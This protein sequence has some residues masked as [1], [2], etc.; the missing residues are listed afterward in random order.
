MLLCLSGNR[1]YP[2]LHILYIN[3]YY[4]SI[5]YHF[6]YLNLTVFLS[7]KAIPPSYQ[8]QLD[9]TAPSVLSSTQTK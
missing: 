7:E 2:I 8:N 3:S 5:L 6:K 4:A 1:T 9:K